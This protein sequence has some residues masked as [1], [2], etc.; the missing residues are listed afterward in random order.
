MGYHPSDKQDQ[1]MDKTKEEHLLIDDRSYLT[2]F[3]KKFAERRPFEPVNPGKILSFIPGTVV[4]ILVAEGD[5][6]SKGDDIVILDAMKMK[7]R[8]KSHI[9]GVVKSVNVNPGDRVSKGA[10]LVQIE[11]A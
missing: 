5:T 4:E 8:L 11:Q 7:N 1:A 3:S 6:V 9:S 10:L 2:H